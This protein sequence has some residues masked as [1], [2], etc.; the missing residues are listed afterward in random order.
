MTKKRVK[1][2]L[3]GALVCSI[4][5]FSGIQ[6]WVLF[7]GNGRVREQAQ[8]QSAEAILVLGAYVYPDGSPCPILEDRL[9]VGLELYR[10]G[11]A[12]KILVSG[13]HGQLSY[14]EVNAMRRYLEERGVPSH[15]IFLD[16][17][18]FDTY[19]SLVRARDVF[20]AKRL[21][22][23][24]QNFHLIRALYLAQA[25]GLSAQGVSSDLRPY[26]GMRYLQVRELGARLKAFTEVQISREPIFRGE[27]IPIGGDGRL[28][29]DHM[30]NAN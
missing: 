6:A 15:D 16:H 8:V 28:T 17:A 10:S 22:V 25:L 23:V 12:P 11:K 20:G 7:Q 24:T 3:L 4:A 29:H 27:V 19:N 30:K 26:A 21:L 14:D 1:R 2:I 18:G 13:D 5:A 9:K